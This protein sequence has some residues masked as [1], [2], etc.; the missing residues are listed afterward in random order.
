M[1][2]TSPCGGDIP[3]SNPGTRKHTPGVITPID[4]DFLLTCLHEEALSYD[5]VVSTSPCGGD[6]P[7][8]NPGTRKHTPGVITPI[9]IDFLLTCLHEEALSYDIPTAIQGER[10]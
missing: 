8:S 9:D 1:V 5:I 3:G 2:S 10:K 6:I 4:I 7:G